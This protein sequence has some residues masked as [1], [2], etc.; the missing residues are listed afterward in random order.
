M[1]RQVTRVDLIAK[2]IIDIKIYQNLSKSIKI[3]Q[4]LS[5]KNERNNND[6]LNKKECKM[7]AVLPKLWKEKNIFF[8]DNSKKIKPRSLNKREKIKPESERVSF[9]K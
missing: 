2:S 7:N 3:Y 1:L 8:M 6:S 5:L 4:N 9:I